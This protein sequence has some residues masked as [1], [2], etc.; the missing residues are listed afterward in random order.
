M[1]STALPTSE[2]LLR[3]GTRSAKIDGSIETKKYRGESLVSSAASPAFP[4]AMIHATITGREKGESV[5]EGG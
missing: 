4:A 1:A 2:S 3:I 5:D